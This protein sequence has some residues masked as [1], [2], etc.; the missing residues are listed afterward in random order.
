MNELIS[1]WRLRCPPKYF[2]R[3]MSSSGAKVENI[4]ML[5]VESHYSVWANVYHRM[6][7]RWAPLIKV[8]KNQTL[9]NVIFAGNF[10][11]V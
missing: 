8:R 6:A 11:R 10:Q 2:Q 3:G 9:V 1:K 5:K 7:L 4:K